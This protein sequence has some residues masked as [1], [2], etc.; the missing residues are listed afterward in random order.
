MSDIVVEREAR[1][2]VNRFIRW[3]A[4]IAGA[5]TSLVLWTWLSAGGLAVGLGGIEAHGTNVAATSKGVGLWTLLSPILALLA[6]GLLVGRLSG[7]IGKMD[8]ALN[9]V[10]AWAVTMLAIFFLAASALGSI[11]GGVFN[12]A[13]GAAKVVEGIAKTVTPDSLGIDTGPLGEKVNDYLKSTGKPALEPEQVKR[14][15]FDIL[16]SYAREG[17][18]SAASSARGGA[19]TLGGVFDREAVVN[20]VVANSSLSREDANGLYTHV[21]SDL[22]QLS[23]EIDQKLV[24]AEET[25]KETAAQAART[26]AKALWGLVVAMFLA[27]VGAVVGSV[28]GSRGLR[29]DR[30]ALPPERGEDVTTGPLLRSP[31]ESVEV[32]PH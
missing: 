12:I 10:V 4:V 8:A 18:Q 21:E 16:K 14:M 5:V 24:A 19:K 11:A 1:P 6:G 3:G 20:A 17:A 7:A 9:G 15:G 22:K 30:I 23:A 26:A 27:L 13:G 31:S 28:L 2:G 29:G 25:A 32:R